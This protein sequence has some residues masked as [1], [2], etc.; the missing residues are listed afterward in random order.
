MR[1]RAQGLESPLMGLQ[2]LNTTRMLQQ[3][4]T[5][6]GALLGGPSKRTSG[7]ASLRALTESRVAFGVTGGSPL[8]KLAHGIEEGHARSAIYRLRWVYGNYEEKNI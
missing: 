2:L 3:H 1:L 5:C 7:P 8:K 6:T 4:C